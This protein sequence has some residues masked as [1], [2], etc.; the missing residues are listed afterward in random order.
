M[1]TEFLLGNPI[2][3][4]VF[5]SFADGVTVLFGNSY[6]R[7]ICSFVWPYSSLLVEI[8]VL[9]QEKSNWK[10]ERRTPT[11]NFP[12]LMTKKVRPIVPLPL[13]NKPFSSKQAWSVFA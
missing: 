9:N 1:L 6:F 2:L 5:V 10:I 3:K 8:N 13:T 7:H 12:H 11:C 4:A